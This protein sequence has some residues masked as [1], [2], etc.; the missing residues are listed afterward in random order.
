MNFQSLSK[1]NTFTHNQ[2]KI[3]KNFKPSI[4]IIL[5]SLSTFTE[6]NAQEVGS[7][8][9][10]PSAGFEF[11]FIESFI[12]DEFYED[13]FDFMIDGFLTFGL[14]AGKQFEFGQ[15]G[16]QF[17]YGKALTEDYLEEN[18]GFNE[19]VE[20]HS[21]W[22]A[23]VNYRKL[24]WENKKTKS[25]RFELGNRTSVNVH[26]FSGIQVFDTD[27]NDDRV[28]DFGL[29]VLGAESGLFFN[30]GTRTDGKKSKVTV[31]W[32]PFYFRATTKGL[33]LGLQKLGI[34]IAF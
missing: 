6:V 5:F 20:F 32:E 31:N 11:S 24:F 3:M 7:Y 17:R 2:G 26:S 23:G 12:D 4:W 14:E 33:G 19:D 10:F 29:F 21:I 28:E 34:S 9:L 8:Y 30:F 27:G 22:T 16:F 18:G 1:N 25:F 13:P 15:V